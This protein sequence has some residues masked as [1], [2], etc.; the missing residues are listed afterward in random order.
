M[1]YDNLFGGKN[2]WVLETSLDAAEDAH[3]PTDQLL[4]KCTV[5]HGFNAKS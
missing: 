4:D 1:V 2:A 3:L 5:H